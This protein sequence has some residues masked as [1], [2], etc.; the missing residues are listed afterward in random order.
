[1]I[2]VE[3]AVVVELSP[4][5]CVAPKIRNMGDYTI[6]SIAIEGH[7]EMTGGIRGAWKL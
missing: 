4:R 2:L 5:C 3:V 7:R 1:M 6:K